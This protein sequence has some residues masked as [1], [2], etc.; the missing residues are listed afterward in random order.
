M[1][2]LKNLACKG[3][4]CR[5]HNSW[6]PERFQV[7]MSVCSDFPEKIT[8]HESGYIITG[9][10]MWRTRILDML[11]TGRKCPPSVWTVPGYVVFYMLHTGRK[12]PPSVW[13][14]PGYVVFYMLHTGRKCPHQCGQSLAMSCFICT[15]NHINNALMFLVSTKHNQRYFFIEL[16]IWR[17]LDAQCWA[18]QY[19]K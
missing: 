4:T 9:E 7:V 12:C 13:T 5:I 16:N 14:V 1:F 3:L 18:K 8:Y 11:H 2:P 6:F 17:L 10:L 15:I 19:E